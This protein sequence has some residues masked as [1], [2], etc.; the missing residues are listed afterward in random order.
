MININSQV[1]DIMHE[2]CNA[3]YFV[4]LDGKLYHIDYEINNA[5]DDENAGMLTMTSNF[6]TI[7]I[8]VTIK[9]IP[10]EYQYNVFDGMYEI[11][12]YRN[13]QMVLV[14]HDAFLGISLSALKTL[15]EISAEG[16]N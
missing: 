10:E 1:V 3:C 9:P 13:E 11:T 8:E 5:D 6:P 16:L 4:T 12:V 14:T 2:I 7:L 15:Y